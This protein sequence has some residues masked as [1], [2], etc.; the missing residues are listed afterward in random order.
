MAGGARFDQAHH[1]A[2]WVNAR[3]E[4]AG[5]VSSDSRCRRQQ[6]QN[7]DGNKSQ[8]GKACPAQKG[9]VHIDLFS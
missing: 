1:A 9:N 8:A 3:V 5:G 4:H 2:A 7:R 6:D